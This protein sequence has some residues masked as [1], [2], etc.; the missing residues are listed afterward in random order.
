M[1]PIKLAIMAM[2]ERDKA[3]DWFRRFAEAEGRESARYRE[4]ALGIAE[5]DELL[6]KI[7]KLPV[8]K[9]QPVL[10]LTCARVAGVP[11]IGRAHV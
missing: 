4:W 9:R 7:V 3:A 1:L 2:S 5:D 6:A 10:L 11:Q 8:A